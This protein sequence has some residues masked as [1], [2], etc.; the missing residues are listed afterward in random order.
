MSIL[1]RIKAAG[2][3]NNGVFASAPGVSVN[4][5]H[6][7]VINDYEKTL[8]DY[9]LRE[10]PLGVKVNTIEASGPIHIW[11]EQKAIP[12]NTT[13]IDP[14]L[15]FGT[16]VADYAKPTLDEDYKRDNWLNA[17]PRMYG[18]RIEYS[19][20]DLQVQRRYGAFAD[21]TS[22]DYQDMI[23]DFTRTTAN[24]FWNGRSAGLDDTAST[25]KFEYTGILNQITDVSAIA[26]GTLISVALNSKIA[27]LQARL[28][29]S[30]MPDVICMNSATYDLLVIEESKR[31]NNMHLIESDILPGFKVKGF[32]SYIGNLPIVQTPFIKPV[33]N[34]DGSVTHKIVALNSALIDRT[35]WFNSAPQ[36]FELANPNMPLGNS[37]LLTNKMM[38]NIDAY[39]LRAP[40]TGAH[41]ILTKTVPVTP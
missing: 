3:I 32:N 40:H 13:A 2:A 14:R 41:F 27:S 10:F 29:Y 4:S 16:T 7:L 23:V 25:H 38:L 22:K 28:D 30:G 18:T 19:Y 31:E 8:H 36:F 20:F 5:G 26:P 1:N 34:G 11:N 24:D 17:V 33:T 12:H 15:G 9:L 35:Y 21:L 37:R 39:I 6:S